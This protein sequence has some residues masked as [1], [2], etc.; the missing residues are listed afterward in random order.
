M[1][2]SILFASATTCFAA[3]S[4]NTQISD[5]NYYLG[6]AN[7][8]G[9]ITLVDVTSIQRHLAD[10]IHLQNKT[11]ME[12]ADIDIDGSVS[13]LDVTHI[14]RFLAN[15]ACPEGIGEIFTFDTQTTDKT[16][17]VY[18]S[19]SN[20]TETMANYIHDQIGGDIQRI[21]PVTP[22]P[23]DYNE[24]ADKAKAQR[25]NDERPKFKTLQYNPEEYDTIFIA[26]QH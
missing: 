7:L 11:A 26:L 19:W 23:E 20:N 14:Q 18:F 9:S 15:L 8:D 5:Q 6:D 4:E 2:L 3:D 12:L 24:T 22:Y 17:I 10:L 21:E 13:M 25:D 1:I 16:L